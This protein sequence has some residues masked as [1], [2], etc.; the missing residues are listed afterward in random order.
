MSIIKLPSNK[1]LVIDA[2]PLNPFLKQAIDE[3]TNNGADIEAGLCGWEMKKIMI[4]Q[5]HEYK[6]ESSH[7]IIQLLQ[8]IHSILLPSVDSI[9]NTLVS[10]IYNPTLHTY[11][12]HH[13]YHLITSHHHTLPFLNCTLSCTSPSLPSP[14]PT[15]S[16]P[17]DFQ[18]DIMAAQGISEWCQRYHGL[19]TCWSVMS[20]TNGALL[21]RSYS[22]W[23]VPPTLLTLTLYHTLL[24]TSSPPP[25]PPFPSFLLSLLFLCRL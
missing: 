3:L 18:L 20:G 9:K 13:P 17:F 19:A 1:F 12:C 15:F 21:L 23:Y 8:H 16:L 4:E 25:L 2:V 24:L 6:R 11:L 7:F 14:F 5:E 22:C 10:R